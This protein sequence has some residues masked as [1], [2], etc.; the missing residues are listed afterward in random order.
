MAEKWERLVDA[1]GHADGWTTAAELAD[2]LGVTTRTIRNYAAQA[3]S[4]G[5]IVESGPA[6]YRLDRAAWATRRTMPR[7][8]T[9]PAVRHGPR[10]PLAHR[11]HRRPR[12]LRDRGREPRERLDL[13]GRPRAR[14]RPARR[15][16]PLPRA[17]RLAHHPRGTRDGAP[18][19]AGH[20]VPRG[21]VARDARARR[22]PRGVPRGRRLPHG[23]RRGARRR[24]V[25]TERVRAQRR[26]AAH[27][28]R[29]RSRGGEPS[30]REGGP[31]A[32]RRR[33]PSGPEARRDDAA[34]RPGRSRS[35]SPAS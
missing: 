27:G 28:D 11:R 25:R 21:V 7:R 33:R 32:G 3:N 30:A 9:S 5:V 12:R 8:G 2:R 26:A 29:A 35:C 23:A 20:A 15:L 14:A 13:R 1:L 6:G 24:R 4:G 19:T 10:H 34:V 18:A 16:R 22:A 31:R 17:A